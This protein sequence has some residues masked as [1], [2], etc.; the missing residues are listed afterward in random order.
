MSTPQY[1]VRGG[2]L[3]FAPPFIADKV[4]YY[5]F[6]LDADINKLTAVCDKYLNEPLGESRFTPAGPFVLLACCNLPSLRSSAAPYSD[7]GWF[8]EKEIAFWMLVIDKQTKRVYWLL[9]YIWVDNPYAMAMGRELYGFPKGIGTITLPASPDTPDEFAI[10]TLVLPTF[11]ANTEGIVAKLVEVKE[12]SDK[13]THS[14]S[15]AVNDLESLV[16]EI[17]LL[18]G[19]GLSL[20]GNAKLMLDSLDD[21]LHLRIPMVFLKQFRDVITPTNAAFQSIV[22]TMPF[23]KKFYSAKI[24]SNIFDVNIFPCDSH[25]IIN[26]LGLSTQGQLQSKVSFYINFD[27]EI[28]TGTETIIS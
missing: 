3:V 10:N 15:G 28:G 1:V 22:E 8:A 23:A 12:T 17:V 25:P 13:V 24:Y 7:W 6:I 27:F 11:S 18:M 2:E 21:L 19:D 9:P 26:E 4:D 14:V 20:L 5:G 16:K